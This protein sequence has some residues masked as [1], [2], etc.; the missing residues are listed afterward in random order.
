MKEIEMSSGRVCSLLLCLFCIY[1]L[2]YAEQSLFCLIANK[3]LHKRM[4]FKEVQGLSLRTEFGCE[5]VAC[6]FIEFLSRH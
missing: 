3:H 6:H 5:V 4:P 1:L 2:N